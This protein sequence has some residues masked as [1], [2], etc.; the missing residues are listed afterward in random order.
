[1][2]KYG[3]PTKIRVGAA[4]G[5]GTAEAAAAAF[6]L[7][8]DYI[9]TGSINQ[10]SVEARI[11]DDVKDMLQNMNIQNTAIAPSGYLFEMGSKVQVLNRGTFFPVRANKLYELYQRYDGLD[12]IPEKT[13]KKIQRNRKNLEG[14]VR[15]TVF[16]K[17]KF[18]EGTV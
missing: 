17:A 6:I 12:Q 5:L 10:C 1:M 11:S 9:L 13:R 18:L 7:G 14:P 2:Q 3:Y 8:A 15:G 16:E 4:G